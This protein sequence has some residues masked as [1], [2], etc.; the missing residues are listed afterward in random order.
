M[1]KKPRVEMAAWVIGNVGLTRQGVYEWK[2][3]SLNMQSLK[4]QGEI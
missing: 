1:I 3:F 4:Q 2:L